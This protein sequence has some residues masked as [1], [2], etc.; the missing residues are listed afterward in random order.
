M[1]RLDDRASPLIPRHFSFTHEEES[2]SAWLEQRGLR[3]CL[4]SLL[5]EGFETVAH[6]Q[7][8]AESCHADTLAAIRGATGIRGSV[9][10]PLYT[11]RHPP[12]LA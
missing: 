6:V 1:Y 9:P 2:L 8:L 7:E 10:P 5:E 3:D 4:E 11:S 12:L